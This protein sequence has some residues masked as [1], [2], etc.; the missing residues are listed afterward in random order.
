LSALISL[1]EEIVC[2]IP[3][4]H[5]D[6]PVHR[7]EGPATGPTYPPSFAGVP[8]GIGAIGVLMLGGT[9]CP[10]VTQDLVTSHRTALESSWTGAS[11]PRHHAHAPATVPPRPTSPPEPSVHG[12]PSLR[13]FVDGEDGSRCLAAEYPGICAR[14]FDLQLKEEVTPSANALMAS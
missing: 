8:G 1:C 4:L 9:T 5:H 14:G 12:T 7:Q 2:P 10:F 6:P 3:D 13:R 11:C